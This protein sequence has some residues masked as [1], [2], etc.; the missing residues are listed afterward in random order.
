[1]EPKTHMRLAL[2]RAAVKLFRENGYEATTVDEIAA[3]AG[4]SA[5]TFFRYF[6]TKEDVLFI[7]VSA[8]LEQFRGFIA[9]PIPGLSRWDQVRM[10]IITVMRRVAEPTSGIEDFTIASW[11]SEPAIAR[12]FSQISAELEH[13]IAVALAQG[14]GLDPDRDVPIQL[15]ARATTAA[16]MT[17]FHVH[18]NTGRDLADLMEE[19]FCAIEGRIQLDPGQPHTPRSAC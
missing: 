2:T 4:C 18:V 9:E 5:R 8:L 12:R 10:S 16:Y 6:A 15:L 3:A 1:V 7:N 11:L 14:T 17:A 19:V 13:D